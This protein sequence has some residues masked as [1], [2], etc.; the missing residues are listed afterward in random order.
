MWKILFFSKFFAYSSPLENE[1]AEKAL[2]LSG[3][4]P[5]P[6][7]HFHGVGLVAPFH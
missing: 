2:L 5:R 3:V 1:I 6:T 7:L 4:K